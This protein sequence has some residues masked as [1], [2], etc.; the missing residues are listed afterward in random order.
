MIDTRNL[1]FATRAL[2]EL[3]QSQQTQWVWVKV[4]YPT[5]GDGKVAYHNQWYQLPKDL[6]K[7]IREENYTKDQVASHFVGTVINIPLEKY[8]GSLTKISAGKILAIKIS[9]NRTHKTNRITRS[10]YYYFDDLDASEAFLA[11]GLHF[12]EHDYALEN[13]QRIRRAVRQLVPDVNAYLMR[14][15]MTTLQ[16]T[17]S[18]GGWMLFLLLGTLGI[19]EKHSWLIGGVGFALA[20]VFAFVWQVNYRQHR[21]FKQLWSMSKGGLE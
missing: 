20:M 12:L 6:Q 10:Q 5:F 15:L 1:S 14:S 19:F 21:H 13:Q 17:V 4:H 2:L 8:H 9:A 11:N 7:A 3:Q 18:I 16:L